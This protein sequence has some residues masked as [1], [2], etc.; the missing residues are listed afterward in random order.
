MVAIVIISR[1]Q[2]Q[3][4][5]WKRYPYPKLGF[6]MALDMCFNRRISGS[7]VGLIYGLNSQLP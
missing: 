4:S 1:G 7:V 3:V 5:E 2:T 6:R